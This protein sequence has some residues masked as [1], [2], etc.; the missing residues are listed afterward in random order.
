M[1][2]TLAKGF[3]LGMSTG[4]SCLVSCFPVLL[5]VVIGDLRPGGS[6][7]FSWGVLSRFLS[8][9]AVAYMLFGTLTGF[10][11]SRITGMGH[12]LAFSAMFLISILMITY[13]LGA[14]IPHLRTCH[15]MVRWADTPHFPIMLGFLTGLNICPPLLLAMSVCVADGRSSAGGALFFLAFFVA[16]SLYMVPAGAARVFVRF[17]PGA[18]ATARLA[19]VAV[20]LFF[21]ARSVLELWH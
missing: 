16:S 8:G 11:G 14:R 3:M 19:A 10:L 20:G 2:E 15:M 21:M 17:G 7:V 1:F 12:T 18:T 6:S 4:P 13:G 5:P 9:R